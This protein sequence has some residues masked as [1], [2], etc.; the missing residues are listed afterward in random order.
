MSNASRLGLGAALF[1]RREDGLDHRRRLSEAEAFATV[2]LAADA[3]VRLVDTAAEWGGSEAA[4]GAVLPRDP[5]FR[6][7]TK[8][9]PIAQGVEAVERRARA[10]LQRLGVERAHAILVHRAGDLL[11]PD[12][13][14]LWVRLRRLKDEGLYDKIGVAACVCDDPV[15]LARRF[16]PDLMQLPA[17]LGDQRLIANGA[18]EE[19]AGRGVEI[20]LRSAL[21]RGLL[22]QP[23]PELA[24]G[25]LQALAAMTPAVSRARRTL[26]EAGV[27]PLQAA[28]AFAL[29]RPEASAVI[30]G[31]ATPNELRAILAAAL[32]PA[33]QVDWSALAWDQPCLLQPRRC[34]AA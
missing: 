28:L 21:M 34:A 6:M 25:A 22:F 20:H 14:A 12:G 5:S 26:A 17:S 30:V 1:G 31:V 10:S 15:S 11:G 8:T 32:A 27:D 18:L 2:A 4:L 29:G 19:I 3:G 23:D 13:A 9:A 33:P 24:R 7:V 16:K